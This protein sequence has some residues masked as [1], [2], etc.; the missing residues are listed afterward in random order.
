MIKGIQV[1]LHHIPENDVLRLTGEENFAALDLEEAGIVPIGP[2]CYDLQVGLS[3]G[4]LFA[5]GSLS[6]K[7]R[8]TCVGC[9]ESFEYQ[10]KTQEF[11]MQQELEGSELVDLTPAIREDIHL[12]LPMHPRCTLGGNK[13]PAQF[14][15]RAI[16]SSE[17]SETPPVWAILDNIN[18]N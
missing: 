13:C 6:Q 4:G 5:T 12:L 17:I 1:H 18:I 11:A 3:E 16:P 7:M 14:P 8:V 2:L 10:F 15:Q 9:L